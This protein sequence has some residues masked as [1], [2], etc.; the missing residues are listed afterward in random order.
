MRGGVLLCAAQAI[1]PIDA[2][3]AEKGHFWMEINKRWR[4]NPE[5]DVFMDF[6]S[7][8]ITKGGNGVKKFPR[9]R[10]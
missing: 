5:S 7:I 10:V 3:I 1:P 4:T 9:S 2:E 8:E 6:T